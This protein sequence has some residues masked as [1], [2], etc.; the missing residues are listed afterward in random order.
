NRPAPPPPAPA[1][2]PT[3]TEP[4]TPTEKRDRERYRNLSSLRIALDSYHGKNDRYPATLDLLKPSFLDSVPADPLT[5]ADYLYQPGESS[6]TVSFA[7]EAGV[8]ALSKGNHILTNRGFDLPVEAVPAAPAPVPAEETVIDSDA[9]GLSDGEEVQ[10]GTNLHNPDTDGDE[11][12]DGEEENVYKT[13]PLKADTDGDG[14]ND[15]QEIKNGYNP[16]GP[17]R[18]TGT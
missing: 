8:F 6:Y 14:F 13:D 3:A 18:G 12:N 2:P 5:A 7:L 17:G 10:I 11:L 16:L 4:L 1:H 9:D 15:G